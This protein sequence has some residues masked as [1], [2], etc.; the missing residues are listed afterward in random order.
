VPYAIALPE[1]GED[2]A[3]RHQGRMRES[4]KSVQHRSGGQETALMAVKVI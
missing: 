1:A 4:V 2:L 3:C